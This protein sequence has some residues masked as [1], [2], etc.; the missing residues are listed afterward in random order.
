M[1]LNFVSLITFSFLFTLSLGKTHTFNWTTG[2]DYYD[3][4]GMGLRPVITCNGQYPWP[5]IRVDKGDRV[6]IYL[7]NGFNDSITTTTLHFHGIFQTG[8]AQMDGP[9]MVTNCPIMQGDTMFYNFTVDGQ[10]G[11]YWYHSHTQGQYEDGFRALFVINDGENNEDFPYDYDQEM[12][13]ALGEW[14]DR[15]VAK[16]TADFLNLYNPTG[17]EPIPQNL[18]INNTRNLTWSVEPDTTYLLR[19]ANYGGFV[20]QYFWLED[21]NMTVVQV[22]GVYTKPNVT[23]RLYITVGQRFSVLVHTKNTTDQN[24]AIMQKIDDTMLDVIPNSL[25]LNATSY[26]MYDDSLPKPEQDIVDSLDFLDD[27]YLEPLD[28]MEILPEP[29]HR[30]TLSVAMDNLADGINY[31]FFN[32]ITYVAPKVPTLM[33]VLSSGNQSTDEAIYGSNTNTFVLKPNETVEIV[34][35]NQDTGT[36]PFHLHGHVFQTLVRDIEYNADDGEVP[37]SYDP[38][39]HPPFPSMPMRRDTIFLRPQSNF[40]IR[41]KADNPGVWFFHCHIEWHILQGLAIVLVEDPMAIQSAYS[42]QLTQ[43]HLDIC[44]KSNT[45]TKGNAAGNTDDFLNLVGENVQVNWIPNGF[46]KKGIVAMTF[47]C[48][49]GI[50]GVCTISLYGLQDYKP[51]HADKLDEIP[52]EELNH[53]YRPSNDNDNYG[54]SANDEDNESIRDSNSHD[55]FLL[56]K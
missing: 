6:E 14:Y 52:L 50:L 37:H 8:T 20:S 39:N 40:V 15:T 38:D 1:N 18:I 19:I 44:A 3:V 32:N 45:L 30:I 4:D 46:T 5:D 21:H 51:V 41:F 53:Y 36:H 25:Q 31:A 17:A 42:Q 43:N 26:M 56:M 12:V 13:F 34:L 16:L 28:E 27:F 9:P 33:T 54:D 47:S 24:Y 2:W 48:L 11:T 55:S 49:A 10:T 23:D 22:D 29:D 7:T 35:N